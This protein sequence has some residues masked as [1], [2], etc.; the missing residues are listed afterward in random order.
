M[1]SIIMSVS[2]SSQTLRRT[3]KKKNHV[4]DEETDCHARRMRSLKLQYVPLKPDWNLEMSKFQCFITISSSF[5]G[6]SS[7]SVSFGLF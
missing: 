5:P 1:P 2:F 7:V 4:T 3:K 6:E